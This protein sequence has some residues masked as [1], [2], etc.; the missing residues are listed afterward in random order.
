MAEKEELPQELILSIK[1]PP[2]VTLDRVNFRLGKKTFDLD[3]MLVLVCWF[4]SFSPLMLQI[5]AGTD[6]TASQKVRLHVDLPYQVDDSKQPQF[7]D[8]DGVLSCQVAVVDRIAK[9]VDYRGSILLKN[10]HIFAL[11]EM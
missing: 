11:C 9:P 8:A 6:N 4:G 3:G 1:L 2:K 10:S 7:E 5:F